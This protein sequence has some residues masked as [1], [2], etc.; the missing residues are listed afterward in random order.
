MSRILWIGNAPF[1]GSGYGEQCATFAPRLQALGH[2]VAVLCNFGVQE[3]TIPWNGIP[4]Y[5]TD[6]HHGNKSVATWADKHQADIIF[7]L[8][9]AFVMQPEEWPDDLQMAIWAPIDHYPIVPAVLATLNHP[10]VRPVA[11]SRF[12]EKMMTGA[13]LD[14]LYCP[15][16]IDTEIFQPKPELRDKVRDMIGVPRDAFLA[17][18]V[19]ANKSRAPSRKSFSEAFLAFSGFAKTHPDAWLYVHSQRHGLGA[20][21]GEDLELL[22]TASGIDE[23]RL[24][25]PE[26]RAWQLGINSKTVATLYQAFDVLL[27][28]S[29][30]EGFGI[31][32]IE[33]QAC[34]VPVIASNHSAMTELTQ[35]GWLVEG[36]PFWD[37]GASAYFIMP[38]IDSITAALEAAY[39]SRHDQD[40]RRA[41]VEFA[42]Q[43]DA[44]LVAVEFME[45]VMQAL[46]PESRQVRRAK[47]RKR[48]KRLK[49]AA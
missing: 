37:S 32:I 47:E 48:A 13:G 2:D 12:G 17:G 44:D 4:I 38:F 10:K 28:P 41:A 23:E 16:G 36:Q 39:E 15:H 8:C 27:I 21:L 5:P 34:G 42:Q 20:G 7:A 25:M 19:S 49:V 22:A 46:A 18:M 1:V 26:E 3:V 24:R 40:L 43:Y 9:D 31:P 30:G 6:N 45:P 35:A 33:A 14:P 11:M 29:M